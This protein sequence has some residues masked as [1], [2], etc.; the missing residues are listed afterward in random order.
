M[1]IPIQTIRQINAD[2]Q[3]CDTLKKR[4]SQL[5]RITNLQGIELKNYKKLDLNNQKIQKGDFEI[6]GIYRQK[7]IILQKL[8]PPKTF[9][10]KVWDFS[11]KYILP[12][13]IFTA[14]FEVGKLTKP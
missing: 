10:D 5:F 7:E 8:P 1:L 13:A 4:F 14:G 2:N 11:V 12:A 9:M 3:Q 6:Q